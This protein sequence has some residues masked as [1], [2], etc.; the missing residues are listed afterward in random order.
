MLCFY[1]NLDRLCSWSKSVII[2]SSLFL[3][4]P[5]CLHSLHHLLSLP[6]SVLQYC[7]SCAISLPPTC[8]SASS[9]ASTL[10]HNWQSSLCSLFFLFYCSISFTPFLSLSV[11]SCVSLAFTQPL[12]V[13]LCSLSSLWLCVL[14]VISNVPIIPL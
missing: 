9:L 1:I 10:F 3:C 5:L 2:S 11:V 7:P 8:L 12:L 14:T 13:L 4:S 6:D